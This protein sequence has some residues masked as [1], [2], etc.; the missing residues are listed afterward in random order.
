MCLRAYEMSLNDKKTR[1][2]D[3]PRPSTENWIQVLNRFAFPNDEE[4]RFPT[5]RS[6]LDL[7]LECS[8]VAGK[9]TP[10]NYA[11]KTLAGSESPRKLNSRAKRSYVQEAVN[12]AIAYP[13][14]V[15]LLDKFVFDRYWHD[16]IKQRIAEFSTSLVRLGLRKLYPD[17][18]AHAL[19]Y[20]RKHGVKLAL[21]DADL[22][23][24]V[25]LDDCVTNVLLL[26]YATQHNYGK[27]K[28][29][30]KKRSDELKSA[31]LREKDKNWLLIYEMW[32]EKDLKGNGQAFLANLKSKGFKFLVA[33][34]PE[35]DP[36]TKD[37]AGIPAIPSQ[38]QYT[39]NS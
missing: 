23:E 28:K 29:A 6:F 33:N 36:A 18:I 5:V 17:T 3:L 22:I 8:Q 26:D 32:S 31:D 27:F 13:Y 25:A 16:G 10:L 21:D 2:L 9:S 19:H 1:I 30:I 11:I 39:V 37:K 20:A 12:L 24:V 4:V 15:P 7:A 14:L 38:P 35:K 34:E